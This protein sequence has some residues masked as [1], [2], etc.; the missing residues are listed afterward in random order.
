MKKINKRTLST[1]SHSTNPILLLGLQLF[2]ALQETLFGA[3]EVTGQAGDGDFI[4]LLLRCRHLN[5]NLRK[6]DTSHSGF[7]VKDFFIP[8]PTVC[9]KN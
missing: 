2:D 1:Y 7:E 8:V 5:I 9:K 6:K 3:L 4:R